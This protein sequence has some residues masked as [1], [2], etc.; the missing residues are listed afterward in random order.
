MVTNPT[1]LTKKH[2]IPT[3]KICPNLKSGLI[4]LQQVS[5]KAA[6]A[7]LPRPMQ[8]QARDMKVPVASEN[9][10]GHIE[11][12]ATHVLSNEIKQKN[13]VIMASEM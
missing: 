10:P 5:A 4:I 3:P 11:K 7:A 1:K 2:I 6:A 12:A 13:I 9:I 8:N